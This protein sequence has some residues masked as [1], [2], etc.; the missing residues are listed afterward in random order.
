[1]KNSNS[2]YGIIFLIVFLDLLGA[3]IILPLLP[4][5]AE[6]FTA[7]AVVI[8]LLVSSYSL[9]QF[10]FAPILGHLS[11]KHGRKPILI[12]SQI[13]SAAGY[14][15]LA[16]ANSIYVLF[17]SRI[18]DGITGGNISTAQAYISDISSEKDKK[19]G[20]G[21][22]G[23]AFGLGFILGPTIGGFLGQIN[24]MLPG[25]F[26]AL[27]ALTASILVYLKLPETKRH[28]K[29]EKY[30]IRQMLYVLKMKKVSTIFLSTLFFG[31]AVAMMQST[32]ALYTQKV[33]G[34]RER[35]NGLMFAY[36]G[37]ISI[38]MQL[39]ILRKLENLYEDEKIVKIGLMSSSIGFL[40]ISLLYY[41]P[42]ILLLLFGL[43][44]L[45]FGQGSFNPV[46]RA[47]LTKHVDS[48]GKYLGLLSSYISLTMIIG[49]F[50]AGNLFEFVNPAMP[51]LAAFLMMMTSFFVFKKFD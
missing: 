20:F 33:L 43:T 3:G 22:I 38:L 34:F 49:P 51:F 19:K 37:I 21:I 32:F 13:G 9:M 40:I 24:I 7:S 5:Y 15:L 11:D 25:I 18:I 35:E 30:D 17:I 42:T 14:A 29:T 27:A 36:I 47:M 41:Q 39:F 16:F 46:I 45:G 50:I 28:K 44:L 4:F 31:L 12:I 48:H 1:M 8:T 10:I 6:K 26:A 2:K 23:A